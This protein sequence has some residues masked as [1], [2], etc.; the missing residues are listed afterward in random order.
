MATPYYDE[1]QDQDALPSYLIAANNHN[2]GNMNPSMF[3]ED[4]TKKPL[5]ERAYNMIGS[6]V[7]SG[8]NSFY[9][10]AVWV[11]NWFSDEDA[12]YR[13]TRDVIASF[14]EDMALYYD[15]NRK[16]ADLV[17]FIASS[18]V[19][20]LGGVKVFNA[21]VKALTAAKTGTI[22]TNMAKGLGV[23]PGQRAGLI[24]QASEAFANSNLPFSYR[25]PEVMKAIAAGFGQTA[26]ESLAFE[27]AVAITMKKNP[28]LDELSAGQVLANMG[29]GVLLG[30]AIGG[31]LLG[32]G[33]TFGIKS[34]MRS[35]DR[36]LNERG[37][38]QISRGAAGTKESDS[39]L[40]MRQ[41]V[42]SM[43][44]NAPE[45]VTQGHY[46]RLV[47]RKLTNVDEESRKMVGKLTGDKELGS[48]LW[49]AVSKDT[50]PNL[51]AKFLGLEGI[52]PVQ[53]VADWV[54]S[55]KWSTVDGAVADI[56][57]G[58]VRYYYK[59]G[60]AAISLT[61]SPEHTHFI[62]SPSGTIPVA[63][64]GKSMKPSHSVRFL[65]AW[66]GKMSEE[67]PKAM[68]L[69]DLGQVVVKQ[70]LVSW[71]KEVYHIQ[72]KRLVDV[73][74]LTYEEALARTVWAMDDT[75]PALKL[76]KGET[77]LT[78]HANDFPMLTKAYR[79]G[80][81]A[82]KIVDDTGAEL[83]NTPDRSSLLEFIARRKDSESTAFAASGT[84]ET[85]EQIANRFDLD[86][87][88]LTGEQYSAN[89]EDAVFGLSK[90]QK[91]WYN[92]YH[93]N[94]PRPPALEHVK[95]WLK[96]QHFGMVYDNT[97]AHGMNGHAI[98]AAAELAARQEIFKAAAENAAAAALGADYHL[99]PEITNPIIKGV[100]NSVIH[101]VDRAG[102][103]PGL[104]SNANAAYGTIGSYFEYIGGNV[105]RLI[106]KARDTVS[107]TFTPDNYALLNKP[108]SVAEL[109]AVMQ[110]VRHAGQW[111][112][113]MEGDTLILKALRDAGEEIPTIPAH[114]AESIELSPAVAKWMR[115][116]VDMNS[117][118]VNKRNTLNTAQGYDSNWD[119]EIV[120]AP[121]PNPSRFKFHA[122]AVDDTKL[123]SQGDT[124][125]L[126]AA[127][128]ADLERQIAQARAQGLSVYTPDQTA[129]YY[130]ARGL[131]D[132]ALSLSEA[133]MDHGL[134]LTGA[135]AP[136]F[137]LTG[138]P[139]DILQDYM[140]WHARQEEA[141]IRMAVE[142]KYA[143]EF[144]IIRGMAKEYDRLA[145]AQ[146]GVVA[147]Y[148]GKKESLN[149]YETYINLALGKNPR[150]KYPVWN[151]LNEFTE[152]VVTKT[153][154]AVDSVLRTIT[155]TSKAAQWDKSIDELNEIFTRFG[156][157]SP[158]TKPMLE[159]WANHPAG[160]KV[161]TKFVGTQNALLS[162]LILRLDPVNALNNAISSP[163]LTLTETGSVLRQ[164][165]AGRSDLVGQLVDLMSVKLPGTGDLIRS[166]A[167]LVA[168][169]YSNFWSS[170]K[171]ELLAKYKQY[172]YVTDVSTQI[173][174]L[175]EEATIKG[176]ESASQLESKR[177]RMIAISQKLVDLGER[178]TGNR[179]AEELNRFVSA[180]V[181]DQLTT[182][183]V[184]AGLMTEQVA[185]T[186]INTFVNRTQANIVASQRP[187][188]FQGPLG[189]AI[190]LFQSYQFNILQQLL[191][192]VG[193]GS[194]KDAMMLM[195]LQASVFG[196][197]GL[198]G[199]QA[200]NQHIIGT[201]S[202]NTSH[203]DMYTSVNNIVGHDIG[204]WLMY[205]L[206]S[207][208]LLSP[209]LK[210][211]LYSRG[212]ISPR[213]ITV[214]PSEFKDIAIVSAHARMYSA[215]KNTVSNI[216]NGGDVWNSILG[217]IEEQGLSRPLAG[218]A[219][220]ARGLN[221]DGISYSTSGKGNII[222]ANDMMSLA[223]FA[224]LSGAKPMHE[225]IFMDASY[226]WQA[227]QAKDTA[228]RASL[229]SAI[230][231]IVVGGGT[232]TEEQMNDFMASYVK[233]GGKQEEFTKWYT[234]LIRTATVPQVNQ[235]AQRTNTAQ[236][237]YYQAIMGGR[238]LKTPQD[239]IREREMSR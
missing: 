194:K 39:L 136:Q 123:V 162:A 88:F 102:A 201:A 38:R 90:L 19:P 111:K 192:Y 40:L 73:T 236:S 231:T 66:T 195:G 156:V 53:K 13:D 209:D 79:E 117:A 161:L 126:Y 224:R 68:H 55:K 188:L 185:A 219:R 8:L 43:A 187:Q 222:S 177:Q 42:D 181:M 41:D 27:T 17:G 85:A 24:K 51:V 87:G 10:T 75:V 113:V 77:H 199:F 142:T 140:Q 184:E 143:K 104:M 171:P 165:A 57:P 212:D 211:N 164:A 29:T 44:L 1:M 172:G 31:S 217:G 174:N 98:D 36:T 159:A 74:Q 160:D 35:I 237:Q 129:D 158:A 131:Y 18:F 32:V 105:T 63:A 61:R 116:H 128:S 93:A 176:T 78:V 150:E 227:Y 139:Q 80:F 109:A 167:K 232:P 145:Q 83:L 65:N 94:T 206:A 14:D 45:G 91:D 67:A 92:R 234:Q 118:R 101:G 114:V 108:E 207:N 26:L 205:G 189:Q 62:D 122:F 163:I 11:G 86:L 100:E 202:G 225:A 152:N 82:L 69:S 97:V 178:G 196:L 25:N 155:G 28:I 95:P 71:G 48:N 198:P 9:N 5:T 229:G 134:Q 215:L 210:I 190:G 56:E 89:I 193:E 200:I 58:H 119:P 230:K 151:T 47:E 137:P 115:T 235:I 99:L 84:K 16:A 50:T 33:A 154:N 121:A 238:L 169:A 49:D 208:F 72:P 228:L 81:S 180:N 191:R 147:K 133:Q 127:D 220:I 179:V 125:M 183:F 204:D 203:T 15:D 135:S 6:A 12:N 239:I 149:P 110:K 182:P 21:G 2:I 52:R 64:G 46:D 120:Y 96:P 173:K 170:A 103:G 218:A 59:E 37:V 60:D 141:M 107:N 20:G 132:H 226:R 70:N 233:A 30:G 54:K 153:Y 148:L 166:P 4:G 23:L 213:S 124:T 214:V 157:E 7:I 112:Y 168:K 146:T 76:S 197:Q 223:N 221:N 138:S 22:G 130:R 106:R 175:I 186:Y 34:G 216:A 3:R 144:G